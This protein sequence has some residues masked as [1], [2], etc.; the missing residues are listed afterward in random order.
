MFAQAAAK[1]AGHQRSKFARVP[2]D[3]AN[4]IDAFALDTRSTALSAD[5]LDS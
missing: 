3:F 4:A 2:P 5:F 1:T